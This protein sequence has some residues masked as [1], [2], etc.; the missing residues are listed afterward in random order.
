[1]VLVPGGEFSMGSDAPDARPDER[2]VHRVH[3]QPF[4]MDAT[5][6][7]NAQF[8]QF[9]K[10]TGYRTVAERPID[11][12]SLRAQLP[13]DTPRPPDERLQP[14]SLVFA[15]PDHAVSL[16]EP[17]AWWRWT[18]GACWKHPEG[19]GSSINDRLDH[20]VVH[21]AFEDAQAYAAWAGKRLPT[22]AEWERAA[23]GGLEQATFV[24]GHEPPDPRRCNI[25]QGEFPVRNTRLD[26][27]ASTAPVGSY[28]PNAFGLLDMA[29]NVWEWCADAYR[30]DAYAIE[31]QDS[32]PS[33]NPRIEARSDL[34]D[35]RVLR[36]G[37]FLCSDQYCTGYRPSA[38]MSSSP[39]TSLGHTGFRC[40][41]DLRAP[42][43]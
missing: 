24:W 11:W 31:A 8:R 33:V 14:G 28:P 17:A 2:P 27:F 30:A 26:G 7:T 3:L 35:P 22:E 23:R 9:V 4:W 5:E 18:P 36:G 20:P 12:E 1:M 25:W 6:V 15:P 43:P 16:D 34:Q 38:R 29:G 42:A 32:G 10:A 19:P 39:D 13:P 40:V 41:R 21:I 37:S